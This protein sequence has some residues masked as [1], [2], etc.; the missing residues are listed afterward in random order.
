[1]FLLTL[2]PHKRNSIW[3]P[4]PKEYTGLQL[5]HCLLHE[6]HNIFVSPFVT[7]KL[8]SLSFVPLLAPNPA[9]DTESYLSGT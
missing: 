1:M 9:S 7:L 2:E 3:L 5:C 4:I 8:F 6:F